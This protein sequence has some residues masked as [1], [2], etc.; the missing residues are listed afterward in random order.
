MAEYETEIAPNPMTVA[1]RS[2]LAQVKIHNVEPAEAI[3]LLEQAMKIS[4]RDPFLGLSQFRLGCQPPSQFPTA[5]PPTR[6]G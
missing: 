5:R 2:H 6:S 1:G 4:A 3:P